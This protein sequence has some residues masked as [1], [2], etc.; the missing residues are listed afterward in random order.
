MC[1]SSKPPVSRSDRRL[2]ARETAKEILRKPSPEPQHGAVFQAQ[3]KTT[4]YPFAEDL[5]AYNQAIPNGAERLFA[6]FD[7]QSTHR[8]E[9]EKRVV[10][11]NIRQSERGQFLG[12]FTL[13]VALGAAV[14]LALND[15]DTVAGIIVSIVLTGGF[16][17]FITGKVQ[18][19]QD[20]KKKQNQEPPRG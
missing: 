7:K 13:V 16:G 4:L 3:S 19:R 8:Q 11:S 6:N 20:L 1:L 15:H 9:I 12:F 10:E 14:W 17:V 18:Q 5:E 2:A